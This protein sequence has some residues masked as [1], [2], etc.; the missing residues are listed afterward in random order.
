MSIFYAFFQ[1][2]R[3]FQDC[4]END[5]II[6][7]KMDLFDGTS[8]ILVQFSRSFHHTLKNNLLLREFISNV[9]LIVIP[10][11]IKKSHLLIIFFYIAPSEMYK[12]RRSCIQYW[13]ILDITQGTKLFFVRTILYENRGSNLV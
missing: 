12:Q 3:N 13:I 5:V 7:G 11:L 4:Q 1:Y 6:G 10:L 2:C 8:T 9:V